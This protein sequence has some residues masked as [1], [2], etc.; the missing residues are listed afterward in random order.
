MLERD[1]ELQDVMFA[2]SYSLVP[3]QRRSRVRMPPAQARE[4]ATVA[5]GSTRAWLKESRGGPPRITD[6]IVNQS[7]RVEFEKATKNRMVAVCMLIPVM[8]W[9]PWSTCCRL[10]SRI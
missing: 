10:A 9:E 6:S 8:L 7:R 4:V 1:D 2:S 5:G 3:V